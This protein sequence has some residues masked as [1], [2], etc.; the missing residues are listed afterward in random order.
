[1]SEL[2]EVVEIPGKGKGCL[3][4]KKIKAGTLILSEKTLVSVPNGT[5]APNFYKRL[6]SSFDNLSKEDQEKYMNLYNRFETKPSNQVLPKSLFDGMTPEKI[7]TYSAQVLKVFDI[8]NTNNFADG[9][10][11]KISR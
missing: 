6:M 3:A 2:Y 4:L 1:M 5:F 8:Y 7:E 10:A 9:V 11:I